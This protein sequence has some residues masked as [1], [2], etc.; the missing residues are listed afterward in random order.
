[1]SKDKFP[2]KPDES[3]MLFYISRTYGNTLKKSDLFHLGCGG[4]YKEYVI[5]GVIKEE[6]NNPDPKVTIPDPYR[7][8]E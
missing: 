5:K 8:L 2:P 4:S 1:M 7:K 6:D 3:G